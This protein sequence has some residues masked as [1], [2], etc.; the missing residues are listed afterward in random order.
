[1]VTID[2][3][4]WNSLFG[5]ITGKQ[6]F[7]PEGCPPPAAGILVYLVL[8]AAVAALVWHRDAVTGYVSEY[9]R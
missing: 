9:V 4:A 7:L 1:M 5:W 6:C 8:L 2:A 3:S